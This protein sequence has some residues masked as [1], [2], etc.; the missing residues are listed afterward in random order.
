MDW[1]KTVR[2]ARL[3]RFGMKY[4]QRLFLFLNYITERQQDHLHTVKNQKKRYNDVVALVVLQV[5]HDSSSSF[6]DCLWPAKART[7]KKICPW[8][9]LSFSLPKPFFS[10][11]D[12]RRWGYSGRHFNIP[13]NFLCSHSLFGNFRLRHHI[14]YKW[15]G[16]ILALGRGTTGI[17]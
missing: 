2:R 9:H 16:P 14:H 5:L 15:R 8:F 7:L 13:S 11:L 17:F 6:G 3:Q 12:V 4:L 1:V 10:L